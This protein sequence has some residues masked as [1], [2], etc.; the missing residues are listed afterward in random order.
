MKD[1][2]HNSLFEK[3]QHFY[4]KPLKTQIGFKECRLMLGELLRV[5]T[6]TWKQS[7]NLHSKG[8][9]E[10]KLIFNVQMEAVLFLIKW[11]QR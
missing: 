10:Q 5:K 9:P 4:G 2:D 7:S 8:F 3:T 6:I 1:I 11:K